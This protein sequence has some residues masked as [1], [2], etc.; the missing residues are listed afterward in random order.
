M[1]QSNALVLTGELLPGFDSVSAWP[2][3]ARYFRMDD[4][5]LHSEI[6]A[7]APLSIKESDELGQLE[8]IR[9]GLAALGAAVEIHALGEN[10][11]LFVLLAQ[12]PRGPLPH[13]Y[14]EKQVR[15]GIWPADIK[16][17][18]VGSNEWRNFVEPAPIVAAMPVA[19]AAPVGFQGIA[20]GFDRSFERP[21]LL[22]AGAAIHAGFW[23]RAAAYLIDSLILLLPS[24]VISLVPILGL[25]VSLVGR[26]LYF[27]LMESSPSQATLGKRAMGLIVT[28]SNG[29]RIGFG[30]ATG[31]YFGGAISTMVLYVGYM[32][33]GWTQR[34][35]ALHD[36]MADTCVV[37]DGVRP[38]HP[39][40]TV[41]PPMP[42]YGWV[43]NVL[44]LSVFPISILAAIALPA[45]Q[46]YLSRAK[47]AGI[48]AEIYAL[49]TDAE[50]AVQTNARC[51]S[52]QRSSEN[53]LIGSIRFAGVA[54]N[55]SISAT[56]SSVTELP[57]PL[58]AKSIEWQRSEEGAQW[59]WNCT[60]S[61]NDKYLP[62]NC[63]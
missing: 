38:G 40:P 50:E 58:R 18:A 60:S 2:A 55:C 32:L 9:D 31:R 27:A 16:V 52:G 15:S 11:K 30:Q 57:A 44:L 7:R 53:P 10:D 3:L 54:P 36:M 8:A 12:K 62:A 45:Y 33:A 39:L 5:R 59:T 6:L 19:A 41:R 21:A 25:I 26:W 35:Q 20:E 17:A 4:A 43:A 29:Q 56:L 22:P 34:K 37:F 48:M 14:V 24:I 51:L 63:R 23:R 49:K 28:S 47:V 61:I 13:A 42:W 46:D 1:S